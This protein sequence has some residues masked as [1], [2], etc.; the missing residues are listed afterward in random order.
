MTTNEVINE[1]IKAGHKV[2]YYKRKD[3]G[4]RITKIDSTSFSGSKGN[5]TARAMTGQPLSERRKSQLAK[6]YMKTPEGSWGHPKNKKPP[7]PDEAKK[8]IRKAQR[9]FR[10][11]GVVAGTSSTYRFRENVEMF[12]YEEAMKRLSQNIRY[13]Q[14]LAYEENVDHLVNLLKT[15]YLAKINF[16]SEEEKERLTKLI[17][18]IE[19]NK[20]TFKDKWISQIRN[21]LYN[22]RDNQISVDNLISDIE[23]IMDE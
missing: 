23:E 2:K 15:E 22:L 9:I 8:L 3:G 18:N 6:G 10:K 21:K 11:E 1:L 12:G 14:G 13:A 17:K 19:D 16:S 4:V 5:I 20:E 7:I